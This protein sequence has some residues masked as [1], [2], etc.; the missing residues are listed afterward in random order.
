MA[1]QETKGFRVFD[2]GARLKLNAGTI[3]HDHWIPA[4]TTGTGT[5]LSL[6]IRAIVDASGAGAGPYSGTIYYYLL[7]ASITE[8]VAEPP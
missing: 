7:L 8:T 6:P 4:P 5:L 1:S 3:A 2:Q